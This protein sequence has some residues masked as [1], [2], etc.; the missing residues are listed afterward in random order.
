M[1]EQSVLELAHLYFPRLGEWDLGVE[2]GRSTAA[3]GVWN[4]SALTLGRGLRRACPGWSCL[5]SLREEKT[6]EASS[7]LQVFSQP[8]SSTAKQSRFLSCCSH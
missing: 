5:F 6:A 4:S 3:C 1:L 8:K 7:T 2:G